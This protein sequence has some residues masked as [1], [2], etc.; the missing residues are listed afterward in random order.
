MAI[1]SC[2]GDGVLLKSFLDRL[3]KVRSEIAVDLEG[4]SGCLGSIDSP[5]D[6]DDLRERR[7]GGFETKG[8]PSDL[9]MSSEILIVD[10]KPLPLMVTARDCLL[11]I[12]RWLVGSDFLQAISFVNRHCEGKDF[13]LIVDYS[14][15]SVN[16]EWLP[17]L[18][19]LKVCFDRADLDG[20]LIDIDSMV[21]SLRDRLDS[22]WKHLSLNGSEADDERLELL[23]ADAPV[24]VGF[25][26]SFFEFHRVLLLANSSSRWPVETSN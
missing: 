26:E 17:I 20:S 12:V 6:G 24:R 18:D 13:A 25:L 2:E 11:Y 14:S 1:V 5:L 3:G 19:R 22:V 4:R 21:A 7:K 9:G 15:R 8:E 23:L 16:S 10:Q